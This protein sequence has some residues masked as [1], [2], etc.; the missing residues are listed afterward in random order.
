[1]RVKD[2]KE[3]E[4]DGVGVFF[5]VF[6]VIVLMMI[7]GMDIDDLSLFLKMILLMK[8]FD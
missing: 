2:V 4:K 1:M 7:R 5:L 8:I 6:I 3:R